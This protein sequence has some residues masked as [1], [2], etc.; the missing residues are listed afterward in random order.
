MTAMLR[1]LAVAKRTPERNMIAF[2]ANSE[3]SPP[4]VVPPR[5]EAEETR[6]KAA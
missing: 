2:E 4:H 5:R 1:R 6:R 3:P